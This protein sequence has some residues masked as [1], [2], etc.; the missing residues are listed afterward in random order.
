MAV[1][2]SQGGHAPVQ[3]EESHD[4]EGGGETLPHHAGVAVSGGGQWGGG[5]R[6]TYSAPKA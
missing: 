2:V 4:G 5:G 6:E 1:S 3:H